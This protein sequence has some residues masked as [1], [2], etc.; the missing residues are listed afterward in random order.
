MQILAVRNIWTCRLS[1]LNFKNS[2][3]INSK[4]IKF[5]ENGQRL[6]TDKSECDNLHLIGK[7]LKTKPKIRPQ[8]N[9]GTYLDREVN[10]NHMI[11]SLAWRKFIFGICQGVL[12]K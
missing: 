12:G 9:P 1:G 6:A 7:K 10:H 4:L 8:V 5:V 11:A 3:L 2:E